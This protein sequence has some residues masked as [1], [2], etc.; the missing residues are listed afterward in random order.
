MIWPSPVW[1][2]SPPPPPGGLAMPTRNLPL[3]SLRTVGLL[4]AAA[5]VV[6]GVLAPVTRAATQPD[7]RHPLPRHELTGY[8]QDFVNPATPLRLRDVSSS[9]D[10]VA[11]AF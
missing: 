11:V 3:S 6:T 5:L 2:A 7:R 8:W 10:L 4:L 1:P 9:Y